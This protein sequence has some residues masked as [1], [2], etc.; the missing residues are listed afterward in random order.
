[1][2]GTGEGRLAV[3]CASL[4]PPSSPSPVKGEG[5]EEVESLPEITLVPV[6]CCPHIRRLGCD[7]QTLEGQAIP[8]E[9]VHQTLDVLRQEHPTIAQDKRWPLG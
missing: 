8:K 6:A 2:E 4:S 3:P 7:P 5:I 1:M 9:V